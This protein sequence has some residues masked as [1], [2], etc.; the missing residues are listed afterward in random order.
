MWNAKDLYTRTTYQNTRSKIMHSRSLAPHYW[1]WV[2]D[3]GAQRRGYTETGWYTYDESEAFVIGP[4]KT[5]DE[6][7]ER[8][9]DYF[10]WLDSGG[11]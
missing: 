8:H 5:Q 3:E 2:A 10:L 11:D 9:K 7:V 1:E 4:S 6:A